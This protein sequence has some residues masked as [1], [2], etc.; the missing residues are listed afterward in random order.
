[1][2]CGNPERAAPRERLWQSRARRRTSEFG[3]AAVALS[4]RIWHHGLCDRTR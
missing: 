2:G 4:H 1:M 3:E